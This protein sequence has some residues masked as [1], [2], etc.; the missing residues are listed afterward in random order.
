MAF[1]DL[2]QQLRLARCLIT[3]N[4]PVYVQF[5]I[6]ARCNMACDQCNI[7]YA[8]ADVPEV[9]TEQIR[10]IARNLKRIGVCIVLLIGGEPFVRADLPEIVRIFLKHPF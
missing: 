2:S 8:N 9:N 4:A 3:R 5:Y 10:M 6:T 7:I 1:F